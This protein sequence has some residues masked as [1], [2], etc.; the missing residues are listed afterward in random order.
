MQEIVIPYEPRLLQI[1][2][3][4]KAKRFNAFCCHRRFGKTV[5]AINHLIKGGV[6][7]YMRGK[8][9]PRLHYLAPLYSQAK[10]V[11]WD[12]LLHYTAPLPGRVVNTSELRVD[13]LDGCRIQLAGADNPDSLR[14]IY[15]D[16]VVLDEYAQMN[17][18]VWTEILV[19]ALSDRR[20]WAVFIGT[21]QGR[22]KFYDIC[23][24]AES[25]GKLKKSDWFYAIH[26]ASET[27]LISQEELDSAAEKMSPE[28]YAQEF[29]CSWTAAIRGAYYGDLM[30]KL[31]EKKQI[32]SV[33]WEPTVPVHT[34]WDLGMDDSTAIWFYQ[35]VGKEVRIIDFYEGSGNGLDHYVKHLSKQEYVYG[36]HWFPHDVKVR[37]LGTGKSRLET[38]RSLG[39]RGRVVPQHQVE[40]GIQAVRNILPRCW[41]DENRCKSGVEA[42]RQYRHEYDDKREVYR[43]TPLHDWT[44]H[45]ADSFRYVAMSIR[46]NHTRELPMFANT[47]I[48]N[49][50]LPGMTGDYDPLGYQQGY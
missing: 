21:P 32:C 48:S 36:E 4:N 41:F 42:L 6:E 2:M 25:K 23:M 33:P 29:E 50:L 37:E 26:K 9:R 18:R 46:G 35:Q 17:P 30:Q 44:S 40:D 7:C 1:E 13:F 22:D 12:Y 45:A 24:E 3:H 49:H 16:G 34:V 38:L 11:A 43:N 14:G 15:S 39:V 8:E 31:D 28:E 47:G 27:G 20:G 10:R 19:P 5:W